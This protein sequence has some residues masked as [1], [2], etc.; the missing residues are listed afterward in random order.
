M[1]HLPA[2]R[3][4]PVEK[5]VNSMFGSRSR[6]L[7]LHRRRVVYHRALSLSQEMHKARVTLLQYCKSL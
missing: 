1:R 3:R 5:R 6:K 4:K 7:V 2:S